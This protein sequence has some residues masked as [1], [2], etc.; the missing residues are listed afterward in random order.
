MPGT[1]LKR[2]SSFAR[3]FGKKDPLKQ[4]FKDVAGVK[5]VT[6]EGATLDVNGLRQAIA[7]TGTEPPPFD[8]LPELLRAFDADRDGRVNFDEFKALI[9]SLA[10][11][12][13]ISTRSSRASSTGGG[14]SVEA[15]QVEITPEA[16]P[17]PSQSSA[18]ARERV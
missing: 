4:A 14:A 5:S 12:I 18:R 10:S 15:V 16:Q 1:N 13:S 3:M 9:D 11:G 8:E 17:T 7:S 2:R 6:D